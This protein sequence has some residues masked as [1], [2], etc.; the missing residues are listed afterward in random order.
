MADTDTTLAIGEMGVSERGLRL[1][2]AFEGYRP[3]DRVLVTGT[4]VAG[5]GHRV[6][7]EGPL[8]VS[9]EEAHMLLLHDLAPFEDMINE[10]VFGSVTQGQ[11][12]ALVSLAFN[13]GPRAF[14]DS[15]VLKAVNAGRPLDAANAFD[16]W[17]RA[18]VAG[19]TYVI[20]ALV[21]RRTAEK[22]LFLRP[23]EGASQP[24]APG[25]D[26]EPSRDNAVPGELDGPTLGRTEAGKLVGDA[27]YEL[28]RL[29][30]DLPERGR[31][32]DDGPVG[33]LAESVT[34]ARPVVA[35]L[36]DIELTE[37]LAEEDTV[38]AE[39]DE[40]IAADGEVANDAL[41]AS[42]IAEA[43]E[44]IRGRLD[45]LI[46]APETDAEVAD[47]EFPESLIRPL[48]EDGGEDDAGE[49]PGD[50]LFEDPN[51]KVIAFPSR[52]EEPTLFAEPVEEPAVVIDTLEQDE[53]MRSRDRALALDGNWAGTV[54][55]PERRDGAGWP[56]ATLIMVGGALFGAGAMAWRRGVETVAGLDGELVSLAAVLVGGLIL[57]AGLLY[58]LKTLLEGDE[59]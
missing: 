30:T 46:D 33:E 14:L 27:P 40:V 21:R 56:F 11:F 44:E 28:S 52:T 42:P 36:V 26:L 35:E 13:I 47:V 17:R 59:L 31:R 51:A 5:Y 23:G 7:D 39:L 8:A 12:D 50:E 45:A 18:E 54:G 58:L 29:I 37:E 49:V 15:D 19:Q 38:F 10:N 2:K 53:A 48:G 55:T 34:V 22:A 32:R 1:I 4:R 6:M 25:T 43:A 41:P 20:D 3:V 24:R 57:L 9:R 16:Q